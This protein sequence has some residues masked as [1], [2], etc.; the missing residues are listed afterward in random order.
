MIVEV[1]PFESPDQT[2][3]HSCLCDWIKSEGYPLLTHTH[4]HTHTQIVTRDDSLARISDAAA[5]M[6]RPDNQ[7]R[8]TARDF[9]ARVAKC[10]EVDGEISEHLLRNVTAVSFL[11]NK[12]AT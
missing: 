10:M 2:S 11:G 8:R 12:S 1:D 9:R 7:L 6:E 4:T 3:L 5:R